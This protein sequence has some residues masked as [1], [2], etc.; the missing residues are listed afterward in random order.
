VSKDMP[1]VARWRRRAAEALYA[2]AG[3]T[4]PNAKATLTAIA[5]KYER[6]GSRRR[7]TH[8]LERPKL[9]SRRRD[10]RNEVTCWGRAGSYVVALDTSRDDMIWVTEVGQQRT[11][12]GIPQDAK[13]HGCHRQRSPSGD[14][15]RDQGGD[16]YH[17]G[18][19][20]TLASLTMSTA[21]ACDQMKRR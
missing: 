19:G 14:K 9:V 12:R 16:H 11:T 6:A 10:Q 1:A 13:D 5:T 7:R 8:R 15:L 2:A 21:P 17:C 18:V 20:R 3:M 4:D